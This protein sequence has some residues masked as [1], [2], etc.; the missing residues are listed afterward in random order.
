MKTLWPMV[1]LEAR[2]VGEFEKTALAFGRP[3]WPPCA[4]IAYVS[5]DTL[6][7]PTPAYGS[8]RRL[9]KDSRAGFRAGSSAETAGHCDEADIQIDCN[10]C[11]G[12]SF[13]AGMHSA[14]SR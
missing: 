1:A 10:I 6:V 8:A 11:G 14:I 9:N 4:A 12:N 2:T 13:C 5:F 7:I 3:E